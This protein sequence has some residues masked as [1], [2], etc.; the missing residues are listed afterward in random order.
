MSN[1]LKNKVVAF[2]HAKLREEMQ[3]EREL[4]WIRGWLIRIISKLFLNPY[5]IVKL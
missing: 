3:C 2:G 5:I 4:D 1:I